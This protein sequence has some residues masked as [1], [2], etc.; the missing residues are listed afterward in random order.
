MVVLHGQ[1]VIHRHIVV[2]GNLET[3]RHKF[4]KHQL[5]TNATE[6]IER[7]QKSSF[8]IPRLVQYN[9]LSNNSDLY[10]M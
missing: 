10:Y 9:V 8:T 5:V 1:Y 4:S 3:S 2:F 6:G 7:F